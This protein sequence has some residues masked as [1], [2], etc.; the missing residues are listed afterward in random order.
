MNKMKEFFGNKKNLLIIMTT[1]LALLV[2][3]AILLAI[4]FMNKDYSNNTNSSAISTQTEKNSSLSNEK[5][6]NGEDETEKLESI[7]KSNLPVMD[8][9]TST[10]PLEAGIKAALFGIS[11]EKA[12]AAVAHST[13]YGSFDNLIAGKCDII[14][15]TPLSQE[16]YDKAKQ[17]NITLVEVPVVY[18]GFVFVVNAKNPVDTLTQQQLKDIYS[19]KITNWKEVGGNDAPIVAYQ[20]NETSGSQNYMKAF[21][22][23]SNLMKPLTSFTPASMIGLMDAV[24][25]YD[26]AE[27]AI[28]YSVY[29]YAANMYGNGNEI[30][31][32]KVD[33]VEPTKQTMA[34]QKYPLLNYNYAIYN[35]QSEANTTVDELAAWLL[36]DNGQI[37][38]VNAGYVPIRNVKVKELKIE[39]YT[40]KGTSTETK[41]EPSDFYYI[42]E[43]YDLTDMTD[44]EWWNR[45]DADVELT[46]LKNKSLQANINKFIDD[47]IIRLKSKEKECQAYVDLLNRNDQSEYKCYSN[48]GISTNIECINGYLSVSVS[49]KYSYDVQGGFEY[50]YKSYSKVYDL[51]SGKE[52]AL[53]D[54]FYKNESFVSVINEQIEWRIPYEV[55]LS[56]LPI[57]VKRTYA[58][59]PQSSYVISFN[60]D[61]NLVLTFDKENPYFADGVDFEIKTY[62]ENNCCINKARDMS[63][64]FDKEVEIKKSVYTT[65]FNTKIDQK[66]TQKCEYSIYYFDSPNEKLNDLV[67]N[68]FDQKLINDDYIIELVESAAEAYGLQKEDL[69]MSDGTYP[70]EIGARFMGNRYVEI[71]VYAGMECVYT[72]YIDAQTGEFASKSDYEAWLKNISPELL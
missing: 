1:A 8:G 69:M 59:L 29:A 37:A 45:T 39:A 64:L 28:G 49:L 24:A 54:L 13:T 21:M 57:E 20:R 55:E 27:N 38:M 10:I 62:L 42:T 31:F 15:S 33:G 9:S 52:L 5:E 51:Y 36:T 17:A 58:T 70:I 40:S 26:N 61:A 32:I 47:S 71:N 68:Y 30:K 25:N 50:T 72:T 16:Q 48:K 11:Q 34:A 7:L 46:K 6:Q 67:N 22:K 3:F 14:F 35:K 4:V 41:T 12:E 53:S 65:Y 66:N 63:G 43:A 2:V 44:M 60:S 19:G 56:I 23:D 18:E